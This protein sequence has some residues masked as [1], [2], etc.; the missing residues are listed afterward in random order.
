MF[1]SS[2]H[3]FIEYVDLK[4]QKREILWCRFFKYKLHLRPSFRGK[5]DFDFSPFREDIRKRRR[6]GGVGDTAESGKKH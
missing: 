2:A 6:I 5:D 4:T 1:T 3:L